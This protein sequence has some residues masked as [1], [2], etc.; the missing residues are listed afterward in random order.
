MAQELIFSAQKYEN[1]R[2]WRNGAAWLEHCI[3]GT[4]N[5]YGTHKICFLEEI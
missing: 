2:Q 1:M 4:S 5:E 3:R